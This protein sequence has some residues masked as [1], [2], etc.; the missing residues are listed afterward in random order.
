[1]GTLTISIGE[2]I[3]NQYPVSLA[4]ESTDPDWRTKPV[5]KSQF[6]KPLADPAGRWDED[7]LR[8]VAH[9][10]TEA[11][12]RAA[13]EFLFALLAGIENDWQPRRQP[14]TTTLLDIAPKELRLFPWELMYADHAFLAL[15]PT[16]PFYRRFASNGAAPA[17]DAFPL[18]VL[19]VIGAKDDD[20]AIAWQVELTTLRR[21]LRDDPAKLDVEEL[22]RPSPQ[23]IA[24]V[25]RRF[26]PH[27]FHFIGH[28]WI[29]N[30]EAALR[31]WNGA[32]YDDWTPT[33]IIRDLNTWSVP[34]AFINA[35]HSAQSDAL[36]GSYDIAAAFVQV[37]ARCTIAMQNAIEGTAAAQFAKELYQQ[38]ADGTPMDRALAEARVLISRTP[39]VTAD[40]PVPVL[41]LACDPASTLPSRGALSLN[42]CEK[43][44]D[45]FEG[46]SAFVDR[47]GERRGL[48]SDALYVLPPAQKNL[49]VVHGDQG[50]GKTFLLRW[51]ARHLA[52]RDLNVRYVDF[53]S[54]GSISFRE[55]L[56]IIREGDKSNSLVTGRLND[57]AFDAFDKRLARITGDQSPTEDFIGD[58]SKLF[59]EALIADAAPRP[60]LLC[61]DHLVYGALVRGEHRF[62]RDQLLQ[63]LIDGALP[64]VKVL[65][66][67]TAPELIDD[68]KWF[69]NRAVTVKLEP[70]AEADFERLARAALDDLFQDDDETAKDLL[71]VY[72]KKKV[73]S[74]R[75]TPSLLASFRDFVRALS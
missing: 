48:C 62:L 71:K 74:S 69:K 12:Q 18:R 36:A 32:Q 27:V 23:E 30:G 56:S 4:V 41:Q 35:C 2:A 61:F 45:A 42:D 5:A 55:A 28:G 72:K 19:A 70:W 58:L 38:L 68:L 13:G 31:I 75:W 25:Y 51:C 34:V 16:R 8:G 29:S 9:G 53:E 65:L 17:S 73:L 21:M 59:R 10:A 3:A 1:M 24:N 63:P 49:F 14:G 33:A 15:D 44:V 6:A 26:R 40:W 47:T 11:E 64:N 37:G 57:A 60:M 52:L 20:A 7:G 43:V 22:L 54:G 46:L 66:S 50:S 39:A 67:I